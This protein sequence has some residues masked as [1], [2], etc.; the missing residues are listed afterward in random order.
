MPRTKKNY[1]LS[2]LREAFLDLV[3][4]HWDSENPLPP[5][6][7]VSGDLKPTRWLVGQLWRFTDALPRSTYEMLDLTGKQTFAVAARRVAEQLDKEAEE[8]KPSTQK[9]R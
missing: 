9:Q 5:K 2:D 1:P 3:D 7:E 6:I 4:N 8:A